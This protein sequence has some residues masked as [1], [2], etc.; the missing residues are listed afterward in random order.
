MHRK[1]PTRGEKNIYGSDTTEC[2]FNSWCFFPHFVGGWQGCFR[3]LSPGVCPASTS[4]Q[5]RSS[6]PCWCTQAPAAGLISVGNSLLVLL[7]SCFSVHKARSLNKPFSFLRWCGITISS[8]SYRR[9]PRS[10]NLSL[11]SSSRVTVTL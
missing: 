10:T 3:S 1:L 5:L 8:C 6:V 2:L 11:S 7:S 4:D 9:T